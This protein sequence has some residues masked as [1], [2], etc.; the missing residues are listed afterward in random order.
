MMNKFLDYSPEGFPKNQFDQCNMPVYRLALDD[1]RKFYP[2]QYHGDLVAWRQYM[3]ESAKLH[4]ALT[5]SFQNGK[6]VLSDGRR[7]NLL[8]I[9]INSLRVSE[10]YPPDW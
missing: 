2:I 5:A 8:D 10:P 3:R 9:V 1:G 6:F 4:G 7:I